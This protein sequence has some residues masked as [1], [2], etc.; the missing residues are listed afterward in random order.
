MKNERKN[1]THRQLMLFPDLPLAQ[2]DLFEWAERKEGAEM[3]TVIDINYDLRV[4]ALAQEL[5]QDLGIDEKQ[6][7]TWGGGLSLAN[8]ILGILD[9]LPEGMG[10]TI[11]DD[12]PELFE[13]LRARTGQ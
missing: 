6:L 7:E 8:R 11:E 3:G 13:L 2:G 10:T 5:V 4:R 9:D 12:H 1:A